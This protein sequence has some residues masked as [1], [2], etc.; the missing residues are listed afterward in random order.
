VAG[1]KITSRST[2]RF[3]LRPPSDFD[4]AV[5][6]AS[7]HMARRCSS[8]PRCRPE[9]SL[10]QRRLP[11]VLQANVASPLASCDRSASVGFQRATPGRHRKIP[12]PARPFRVAEVPLVR[13]HVA[14]LNRCAPSSV[15]PHRQHPGCAT[16]PPHGGSADVPYRTISRPW[17]RLCAPPMC[18]PRSISRPGN[19]RAPSDHLERIL[20]DTHGA[21]HYHV[22]HF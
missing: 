17:S 9:P 5:P 7:A 4:S 15:P 20:R 2:L 19:H 18:L 6:P 21:G 8:R 13:Q 10:R 14:S 1:V 3:P 22:I 12:P 11:A 16:G